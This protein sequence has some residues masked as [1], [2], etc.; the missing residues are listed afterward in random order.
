[1][2]S[3]HQQSPSREDVVGKNKGFGWMASNI[4]GT[5]PAQSPR[6]WPAG[7]VNDDPIAVALKRLH[8]NIVQEELPDAFL[9]IVAQI[10]AR[11]DAKR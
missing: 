10:E 7:S 6:A 11:L 1:M 4:K 9:D 3:A 2:Q 8:D 5:R